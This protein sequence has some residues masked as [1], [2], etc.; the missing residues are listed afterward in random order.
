MCL[1]III[2][3]NCF[4]LAKTEMTENEKTSLKS[5][6]RYIKKMIKNFKED[7]TEIGPNKKRRLNTEGEYLFD[8]LLK[9]I[10]MPRRDF[11]ALYKE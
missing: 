7:L 6:R 1:D 4:P 11:E 9:M 3:A 10:G 5:V 8:G 2:K